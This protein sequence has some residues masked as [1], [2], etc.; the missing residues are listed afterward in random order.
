MSA[1]L[2]SPPDTTKASRHASKIV[3]ELAGRDVRLTNNPSQTFV[4]TVACNHESLPKRT[5]S[6]N[7]L[8]ASSRTAVPR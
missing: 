8:A 4:Q 3:F 6:P 2:N 7:A 1:L 5:S